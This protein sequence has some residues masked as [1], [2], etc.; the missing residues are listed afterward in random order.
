MNFLIAA[1]LMSAV[2][3]KTDPVLRPYVNEFIEDMAK[4]D[5]VRDVSELDGVY[6]ITKDENDFLGR[7]QPHAIPGIE[8]TSGKSIY[9][10]LKYWKNLDNL[11][12]KALVYHELF[13]CVYGVRHLSD[14][15][16]M[17]GSSIHQYHKDKITKSHV[18]SG[19]AFVFQ[20]IKRYD[21]Y[22]PPS[23][24]FGGI[25]PLR[26]INRLQDIFIYP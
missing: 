10:S 25:K 18:D 9:I 24:F 5:V 14:N 13:H 1:A 26:K 17:K 12:K 11:Q 7:C 20:R 16:V 23:F 8:A 19:I 21:Q 6:L 15:V 4:Y 3:A 22:R 2:F